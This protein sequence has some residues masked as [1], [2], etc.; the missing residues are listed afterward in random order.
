MIMKHYS[1]KTLL[2]FAALTLTVCAFAID[3]P[4]ATLPMVSSD[5]FTLVED[6]NPVAVVV[7]PTE[8]TALNVLPA[9]DR[10]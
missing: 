8:N 10:L 9:G 2:T 7:S 4:K 5:R 3:H 1:L 6:G